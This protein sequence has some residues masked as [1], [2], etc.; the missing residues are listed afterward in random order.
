MDAVSYTNGDMNVRFNTGN[1]FSAQFQWN[2]LLEGKGINNRSNSSVGG[3]VYFTMAFPIPL[4]PLKLIINP[5]GSYSHNMNGRNSDLRD[6]NG[7][8]LPDHVSSDSDDQLKVAY[9]KCGKTNMLKRVD[10][11][12]GGWF[13]LEY[14]RKGNTYDMPR[15]KWVLSG[16]RLNDGHTGD[17]E[18]EQYVTYEYQGGRYD[19]YA[20]ESYGFTEII[21]TARR[22]DDGT[23]LRSEV[24]EY[25]N[26][27]VEKED[28]NP[29]YYTRG[30]VSTVENYDEGGML[31]SRQTNTYNY[32]VIKGENGQQLEGAD[33]VFPQLVRT[34]TEAFEPGSSGRVWK[35]TTFAYDPYGNISRCNISRD[36]N[37]S[38]DDVS[39]R[40]EYKYDTLNYIVDK[41][42]HLTVEDTQLHVLRERKG[43]YNGYGE[44]TSWQ[45]NDGK[46]WLTGTMTYDG[47]YGNMTGVT[48][49]TGY[50][51][52]YTYDTATH[53]Y[54]TGV[55]DSFGYSSSAEYDIGLGQLLQSMD[56]N[57][58]QM[59]YEYDAFGRLINVFGPY[60]GTMPAVS[61]HYYPNELPA[62]AVTDNKIHFAQG[63][64][65]VLKTVLVID[66]LKRVIQTKKYGEMWDADRE[67]SIKGMNV[68]GARE[69]DVLGRLVTQGKPVFEAGEA[70][71]YKDDVEMKNEVR[72]EYDAM[73]R[74]VL[75]T[76]KDGSTMRHVYEI[77]NGMH[78]VTM[79]DP[80][81][82]E[83]EKYLDREGNIVSMV[84]HKNGN[85][86]TTM[87][88]YSLLNEITR[89]I[90]AKGK[91]ITSAYDMLGR[92][93]SITTP[94][95]GKTEYIYDS[96]GRLWKKVDE[97]LRAKARA[98]E[99][100]YEYSRLKRI[101]YPDMDDVVYEYGGPEQA[102]DSRG[103]RA[104]RVI[105][106][107]NGMSTVNY[108]YGRL[109]ET[110]Q[111]DKVLKRIG[112]VNQVVKSSM[113]YVY[114]Y[115]GRVEQIVYPDGEEVGYY[116]DW[117]GQ[118]NRV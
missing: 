89:I 81:G 108:T 114:D 75:I 19:R 65:D 45:A 15:S 87:Y 52:T 106:V 39:V 57:G 112:G 54:I 20:R 27:S 95:T 16:V 11:P 86:I 110:V 70:L 42:T 41:P 18:D 21:T 104:G 113:Q 72:T 111:V 12:L 33:V 80:L 98:I 38:D 58:Q 46:E 107:S 5:G 94:D 64:S 29:N 93:T 103:N 26:L 69:Y 28:D 10:R 90:D 88:E 31:L 102:G 60:D 35:Y 115:L 2:G 82:K 66:G 73:D 76:L 7:D 34:Q 85:P 23:E 109:G 24:R 74:Q 49:S 105:Q 101:N 117:G 100:E 4:T 61:F 50:T 91:V 78:K 13:E 116:Y 79:I 44:L 118:V 14:K 32:K 97:N 55:S 67:Q 36:P 43:G 1:G 59:R 84:R 30:L 62:R 8:G 37:R 9:N 68:S 83:T 22:A 6:V 25:E 17:G 48:D 53:S 56:I 40:V 96:M 99:Y 47:K 63:N 71:T 51:T 3:G 92:K 77:Y